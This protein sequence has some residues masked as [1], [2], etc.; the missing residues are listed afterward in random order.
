MLKM[1][2]LGVAIDEDIIKVDYKKLSHVRTKDFYHE[3]HE[4]ARGI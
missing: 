2:F 3:T 1:V 4:G